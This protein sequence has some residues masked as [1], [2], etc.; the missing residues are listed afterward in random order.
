MSVGLS[1]ALSGLRVL[2]L[3][4][5]FAGPLC[6]M[7]LADLGA[8]VLKIE[9]PGLGD[10]TRSWGPPFVGGES[11][12]YLCLN[13]N[14]RSLTLDLHD[15]ADRARLVRL[16][17][18]A[19]ILVENFRAGWMG[20]IGLDYP[21]L[22]P[23]NPRIIYCSLTGYG[24]T[25]PDA[26]LP[27]YDYLIQGRAGLMSITGEPEGEPEKVGVA[28]SDTVAGLY[29]CIGVLAAVERRRHTGEG[30]YIDLSLMD[31][32]V[33]GLAN[34]ASNYLQSGAAPP[35]HGNAHPNI[36]PYQLFS[37]ADE[38]FI[39]AVGNDAQWRSAVRVLGSPDWAQDSRF[40]TNAGRVEHRVVLT[41]KLGETLAGMPAAHWIGAFRQAGVPAGPVQ[42]I[43]AVFNDPQVLAR[44]MLQSIPHPTAGSI[45]LPANPLL[46]SETPGGAPPLLGEGG[47]QLAARW[48]GEE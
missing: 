7:L 37:A 26:A 46:L 39:L 15:R 35:R 18:C 36:V 14:K 1:G 10:D 48:L 8:E 19:D 2:D 22:L 20:S 43:P 41:E 32:Q 27:G 16:A 44:S 33:A 25:G 29:A 28:V 34:V 12:Y 31:C 4:R 17:G 30:A 13:R 45:R 47:E 21:S 42:D 24:Q 23:A 11:A 38:T 40:G 6:T 3:S 5:V 9:R